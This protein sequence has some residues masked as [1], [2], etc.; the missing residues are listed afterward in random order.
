[1]QVQRRSR[2][3]DEAAVWL[4]EQKRLAQAEML[5]AAFRQL[6][7]F[8]YGPATPTPEQDRAMLSQP[9]R[10]RQVAKRHPVLSMWQIDHRK[11]VELSTEHE[12]PG[13]DGALR[14]VTALQVF[15]DWQRVTTALQ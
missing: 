10:Y 14:S 1:M 11:A 15:T 13:R 9:D 4:R 3:R 7:L 8:Q 6:G 12:I 2:V 5:F